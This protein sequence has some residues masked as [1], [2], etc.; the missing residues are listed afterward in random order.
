[1]YLRRSHETGVTVKSG[2][3]F[4]TVRYFVVALSS[5]EV[6]ATDHAIRVAG[7]GARA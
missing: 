1:M 2:Y 7:S 3:G 6:V 5:R 4:T